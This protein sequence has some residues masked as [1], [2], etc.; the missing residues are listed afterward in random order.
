MSN[1]T[2]GDYDFQDDD[3]NSR[4][5]ITSNSTNNKIHLNDSGTL[6]VP[7]GNINLNG[8]DITN[9]GSVSTI[10]GTITTS[11]K[12]IP[13]VP[14]DAEGNKVSVGFDSWDQISSSR[15]AY[16]ITSVEVY[17]DGATQGEAVLEIDNSGGT[18]SD[19]VIAAARA[20]PGL[21]SGGVAREFSAFVLPPGAQYQIRNNSDPTGNNNIRVIYPY[22]L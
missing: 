3:T 21:G 7:N 20:D 1:L 13:G 2:L 22:I 14:A 12:D 4:L 6:E 16:V 17:T 10:N 5:T 18:S 11:D 8:G 15:P 9:A 19:I